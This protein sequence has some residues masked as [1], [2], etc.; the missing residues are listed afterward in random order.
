MA[1]D[2]TIAHWP[3]VLRPKYMSRG[4]IHPVNFGGETLVGPGQSVTADAG[5]WKFGHRATALYG[6]RVLTMRAMVTRLAQR[7]PIYITP[8]DEL[9]TPRKRAAVA[10]PLGVTF[11]DGSTFSGG[12]TFYGQPVD[13]LVAT[14]AS[15]RAMTID[16]QRVGPSEVEL[17]AGNYIGFEDRLYTIEQI[18]PSEDGVSGKST[19]S[20]W[21]Y[22]R[23]AIAVDDPAYTEAPIVRCLATRET[24]EVAE[25]LDQQ[26]F[27][28][29]IDLDFE[30]DRW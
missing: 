29:T 5:R 27:F 14:A 7:K 1:Y 18:F 22:L 3:S 30:E 21:P 16:V 19:L 20:I 13:F 9:R 4:R 12:S 28:G 17:T 10:L 8:M 6:G 23:A 26:D 11:S 2:P 15:A 25:T 24:L